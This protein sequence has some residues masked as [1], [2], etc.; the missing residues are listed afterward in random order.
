MC[1]LCE[2]KVWATVA[3]NLAKVIHGI[4]PDASN[5]AIQTWIPEVLGVAEVLAGHAPRV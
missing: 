2:S 3:I 4:A 5:K 1:S